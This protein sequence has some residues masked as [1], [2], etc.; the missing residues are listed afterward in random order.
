MGIMRS[1]TH[2]HKFYFG[3]D[4]EDCNMYKPD[5]ITITNYGDPLTKTST[6]KQCV[7]RG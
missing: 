2:K 7:H 5:H 6:K 1:L 4:N 3:F